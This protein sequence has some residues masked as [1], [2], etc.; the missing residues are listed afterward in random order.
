MDMSTLSSLI[1]L[2]ITIDSSLELLVYTWLGSEVCLDK[3][4]FES[5]RWWS[6][7]FELELR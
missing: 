5:M 3:E 7:A 4:G 6:K 1:E 2:A